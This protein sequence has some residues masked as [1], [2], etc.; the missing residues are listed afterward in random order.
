MKEWGL[1]N[2]QDYTKVL[3]HRPILDHKASISKLGYLLEFLNDLFRN[4]VQL[5][6]RCS[7][8]D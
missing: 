2:F 6:V 4:G 5:N 1:K 7:L 3:Y 8:V